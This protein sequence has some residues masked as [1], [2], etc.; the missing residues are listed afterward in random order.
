MLGYSLPALR[1]LELHVDGASG[2]ALGRR[3]SRARLGN[4]LVKEQGDEL[5]IGR[6]SLADTALGTAVATIGDIGKGNLVGGRGITGLEG[7][8]R[9]ETGAGGGGNNESGEAHVEGFGKE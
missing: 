7:N 8:G 1:D 4:V 2:A 9:D 6:D 5:V 3:G